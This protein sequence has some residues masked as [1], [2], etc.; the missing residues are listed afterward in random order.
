MLRFFPCEKERQAAYDFLEQDAI[1][2]SAIGTSLGIGHGT[3]GF[4]LPLCLIPLDGCTLSFRDLCEQ[5]A[6][7]RWDVGPRCAWFAREWMA[8]ALNEQGTVLGL[9]GLVSCGGI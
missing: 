2:A 4:E 7:A 1:P 6:W 3:P 5:R 8:V 9:A